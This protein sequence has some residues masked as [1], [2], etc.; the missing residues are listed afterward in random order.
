[1][2][3]T[4]SQIIKPQAFY[5]GQF[6]SRFDVYSDNMD[7]QLLVALANQHAIY[8]VN[9]DLSSD[10]K[11]LAKYSLVQNSS[12]RQVLVN[13]EFVVVQAAGEAVVLE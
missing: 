9:W 4:S 8:E 13:R 2:A 6:F 11:L 12:V 7:D 10:P 1:M 5:V 3:I